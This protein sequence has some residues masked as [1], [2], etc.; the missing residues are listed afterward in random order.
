MADKNNKDKIK[1][2]SIFTG[3]RGQFFAIGLIS[4]VLLALSVVF[5]SIFVIKTAMN[6]QVKDELQG[7]VAY[8][9]GYYDQIEGDFKL[10]IVDDTGYIYKGDT[11]ITEDY[12]MLDM[13]S[14]AFDAD[15]SIF[16]S[17]TRVLTTFKDADHNRLV[18]TGSAYTVI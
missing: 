17:G 4:V 18:N 7:C 14:G 15:V 1:K 12:S 16:C 2:P 6:G 3:L 13:F 8:I 11:D 9:E 10:V 5:V